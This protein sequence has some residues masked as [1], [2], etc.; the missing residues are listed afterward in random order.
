M[1]NKYITFL[2]V[3]SILTAPYV[4]EVPMVKADAPTDYVA[5]WD[6]EETSGTRLDASANSI[7]LTDN[8]TVLYGTGKV[9]NAADFERS[10]SEYLSLTNTQAGSYFE[11]LSEMTIMLWFKPESP[12]TATREPFFTSWA[13]NNGIIFYKDDSDILLVALGPSSPTFDS[14]A[15]TPVADTWYHITMTY[16]AGTIK[17]YVNGVQ[18]GATQTGAKTTIQTTSNA[19]NIGKR[20][21]T[22]IYV[23]GLFD[24]MVIYNYE[25]SDT[26]VSTWY[27]GGDGAGCDGVT[28]GGAAPDQTTNFIPFW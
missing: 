20:T 13:S 3:I 25:L 18:Q 17:F 1:K 21:D 8:N 10:N 7:D 28:G 11:G 19:V 16:N 27:N 23:D 2:V 9:G 4:I 5:C 14:V 6:F 24:T 26:E 12:A 15:W 22:S